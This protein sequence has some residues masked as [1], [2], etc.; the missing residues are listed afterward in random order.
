MS[1]LDL[2]TTCSSATSPIQERIHKNHICKQKRSRAGRR[3][4][5]TPIRQAPF[6]QRSIW[7]WPPA[8][9]L[10]CL[11]PWS[12]KQK[13][14]SEQSVRRTIGISMPHKAVRAC[15]SVFLA[16]FRLRRN[17]PRFSQGKSLRR[18][19]DRTVDFLRIFF[20]T[21][22]TIQYIFFVQHN[23]PISACPLCRD[24]LSR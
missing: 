21:P 17:S 9:G 10:A 24:D 23:N 19:S 13:H 11:Y 2:K 5:R 18:I 1:C 22:Q 3:G 8:H 6:Q 16:P 7:E 4:S 12:G 20:M 14:R 15:C